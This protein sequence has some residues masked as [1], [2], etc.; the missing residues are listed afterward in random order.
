[1]SKFLLITLAAVVLVGCGPS[2]PDITIHKAVEYGN[3]Y[4]VKQHLKAG[5]DVNKKNW[6]GKTPLDFSAARY[7]RTS[8]IVQLLRERGGIH[9]S[10]HMAVQGDDIQAVKKFLDDGAD[11]NVKDEESWW[12]PLHY[13]RSKE[14]AELLISKGA[15]VNA[16]SG[17]GD[18]PLDRI[19]E[20]E[21]RD[22]IRKNGGKYSSITSA[23]NIGDLDAVKEF[24]DAGE[25]VNTKNYE[26][27]TML[28]HIEDII[29]RDD[30]RIEMIENIEF[31]LEKQHLEVESK[32]IFKSNARLRLMSDLLRKHGGKTSEELK[33]E[34]K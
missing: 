14:V 30:Y 19:S 20:S 33:A 31:P 16:K 18:L 12:T 13:T 28:D 32:R 25:N 22:I 3:I 23:C 7:P 2:V 1:M 17:A 27:R 10:I 6:E 15:N 4:D 8:K 21:V 24:L 11:I 9:S 26:G 34:G 29:S 5:T